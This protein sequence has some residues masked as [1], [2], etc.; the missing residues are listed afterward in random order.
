MGSLLTELCAAW[1]E[2]ELGAIVT[3]RLA[4]ELSASELSFLGVGIRRVTQTQHHVVFVYEAPDGSLR[5]SHLEWHR[6]F[7]GDAP[8]DGQYYWC[9]AAGMDELNRKT[10]AAWLHALARKPQSMDYGLS[11]DDCEFIADGD[12]TYAF[13][14][15]TPG[16]GVTCATFVMLVLQTVGFPLLD[17]ET[18]QTRP[19]DVQWQESIIQ[20]LRQHSGM[21]E[22]EADLVAQDVGS[23]RFRPIEVATAA[24]HDPWPVNFH[25]ATALAADVMADVANLRLQNAA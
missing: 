14:A 5:L 9:T 6:R 8:W 4:N 21:T 13:V 2:W 18:W 17:A 1:C 24:Q 23:A 11:F 25:T 20:T 3:V 12:G 16:K 15:K 19:E 7:R 22:Q 10:I